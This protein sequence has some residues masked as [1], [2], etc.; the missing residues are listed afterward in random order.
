[1]QLDI[2][3]PLLTDS[4]KTSHFKLYPAAQKMVAYGEFRGPYNK[5]QSDTR[6]LFYGMRYI[7]ENYISRKYTLKDVSD[8]ALFFKTHNAGATEFPFP[9]ALFLKFVKENDGYFP[10]KIQ[11]L[12]EGSVIYP[13]VPVFQITAENEY[14]LLITYLETLLTMIWVWRF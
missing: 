4:Y 7:I 2:P 1:M 10:V 13:H 6:I 5:D 12:P 3:F 14:S 8:A 9:E 11:A